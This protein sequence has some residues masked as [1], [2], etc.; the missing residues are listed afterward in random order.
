VELPCGL[1]LRSD[2]SLAVLPPCM[3]T[4]A[5]PIIVKYMTIGKNKR[6][7]FTIDL[8]TQMIM[9]ITKFFFMNLL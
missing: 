2:E 9:M 6:I 7:D 5:H 8:E 4:G 1:G 3:S